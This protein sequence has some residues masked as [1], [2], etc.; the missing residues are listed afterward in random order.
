MDAASAARVKQW[1]RANR[2]NQ[3]QEHLAADISRATGW[4]ITRDRYSK[5][6]GSLPIGKEVLA[7]FVDYWK[8]RGV[9]GPFD[10]LPEPLQ[11][12][13]TADPVAAAL[14][15]QTD[16]INAL[17]AELRL[18]RESRAAL[19]QEVAALRQVVDGLVEQALQG[20]PA[21]GAR[22]RTAG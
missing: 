4:H 18:S 9:A 3:T 14:L 2:G 12:T 20:G 19:E 1:L 11:A 16:A 22:T 21:R 13:E 10:A 6:E 5:Y 17:V 8:G 15:T 7:H